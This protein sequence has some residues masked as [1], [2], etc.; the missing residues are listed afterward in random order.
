MGYVTADVEIAVYDG[1]CIVLTRTQP[2][3]SFIR[4]FMRDLHSGFTGNNT[5]RISLAGSSR[6]GLYAYYHTSGFPE[7]TTEGG[8]GFQNQSGA[9]GNAGIVVGS[10]ATPFSVDQNNLVSTIPH[11]NGMGQLYR[12][13][14]IFTDRAISPDEQSVSMAFT[15]IFTNN[16]DGE[17]TAWEVGLI[18]APWHDGTSTNGYDYILFAR[19]VLESPIVVAPGQ[20][21]RVDYVIRTVL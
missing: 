4:N 16:S 7:R 19:D 8:F 13:T 18:G 11:G 6:P 2:A 20:S 1:N 21:L 17:V 5:N 14:L 15:R 10:G 12:S 9:G 3:H